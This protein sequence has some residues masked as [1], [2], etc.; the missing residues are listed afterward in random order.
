M[1]VVAGAEGSMLAL[2]ALAITVAIEAPVVA[3]LYKGQRWRM[4]VVCILATSATNLLMNTALRSLVP[5]HG[6]AVILGELFAFAVEA[7]A[8]AS[9]SNPRDVPRALTASAIA[10]AA[11]FAVGACL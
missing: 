4:M 1:F 6:L 3:L 11:S 7:T 8:Y 10:N 5:G 9:A 2:T